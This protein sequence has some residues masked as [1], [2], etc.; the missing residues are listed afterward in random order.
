MPKAGRISRLKIEEEILPPPPT[1][2]MR[3]RV[4]AVGLNFADIF[5]CLGLYGATPKGAFTP[6]LEFSGLVEAIGPNVTDFC[7]GDRVYGVTRF[8]A[9]ASHLNSPSYFVR[10]LPD[11]WSFEEGASFVVQ[12][13]T[14]WHGLVGLGHLNPG[15]TVLVHSAAGGVGLHAMDICQKRGALAIGTVGSHEKVDFLMEK[16]KL[17]RSQVLVR[18]SGRKR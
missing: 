3:I 12:G 17:R 9:Y 13:L 2:Q 4:K 8:G 7:P 11:S 5:A 6:G 18:E 15:E 1:G 14:A 10:K 16:C